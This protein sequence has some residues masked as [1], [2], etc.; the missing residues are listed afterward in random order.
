M[1]DL[2]LQS[3]PI[4]VEKGL[5]EALVLRDGLE[6][7]AVVSHVPDRPLTQSSTTQTEDVT[8]KN[9]TEIS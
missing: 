3:F 6:D 9:Q 4:A 5:A 7:A 2:Y 8:G 1:I